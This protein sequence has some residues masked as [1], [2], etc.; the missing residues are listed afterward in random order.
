MFPGSAFSQKTIYYDKLPYTRTDPD[1][2][3]RLTKGLT[4]GVRRVCH[5]MESSPVLTLKLE[6][7]RLSE[8]TRFE[9]LMGN[10]MYEVLFDSSRHPS[11]EMWVYN[12]K[13]RTHQVRNFWNE[14]ATES[15]GVDGRYGFVLQRYVEGIFEKYIP[16]TADVNIFSSKGLLHAQKVDL[17]YEI[18]KQCGDM[19]ELFRVIRF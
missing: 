10:V 12:N 15:Q 13:K 9:V 2:S 8:M 19:P 14:Q 17:K 1:L 18:P 6:T 11:F 16:S 5:M 4:K 3:K 7:E